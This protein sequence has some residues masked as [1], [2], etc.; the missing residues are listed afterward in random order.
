M[1]R[2]EEFASGLLRAYFSKENAEVSV[3]VVPNDPPDLCVIFPNGSKWGVEVVRAYDQVPMI[4]N[5]EE[6]GSSD[7]LLC[8]LER[9]G[10]EIGEEG[11]G[12]YLLSLANRGLGASW[13]PDDLGRTY[14]SWKAK[15][16]AKIATHVRNGS[17]EILCGS[18]FTLRPLP[19]GS[20]WKVCVSSGAREVPQATH[21][22]LRK[23]FNDKL[24]DLPSWNFESDK[25]WLLMMN[26]YP[27]AD[28]A[29][30]VQVLRSFLSQQRDRGFD[31][32]FW[33]GF[34]DRSLVSVRA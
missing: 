7:R 11:G 33:A 6:L 32:V 4:G 15:V 23:A 13:S 24:R 17:L 16:K 22:S 25:R 27:L 20:G 34:P 26:C 28:D 19:A 30:A 21:I 3:E 8:A 31:G 29:E 2:D 10:K 5:A 18:G 9:F 12:D 1:G 14:I